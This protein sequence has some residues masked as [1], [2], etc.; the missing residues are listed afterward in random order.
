MG[1]QE[2]EIV[3]ALKKTK[4]VPESGYGSALITF[5]GGRIV[6]IEKKESIKLQED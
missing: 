2:N 5:H 4:A 3:E 1:K 6:N